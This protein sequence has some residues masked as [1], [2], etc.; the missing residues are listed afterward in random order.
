MSVTITDLPGYEAFAGC[1]GDIFRIRFESGEV[2]A[3]SLFSVTELRGGMPGGRKAFSLLFR[4][5]AGVY[6]P[7][8]MYRLKHD[9]LG[10]IDLFLVPIAPDAQGALFEAVFG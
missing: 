8:R 1:K 9:T 10:P 3:L 7:Q 4:A 5:A 2:I 6:F